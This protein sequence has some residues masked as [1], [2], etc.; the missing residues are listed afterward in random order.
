MKLL[1]LADL[2][3]GKRV[4]EFPMLADQRFVLEEALDIVRDLGVDALLVAGDLYD[5]ATPSAEAVA[6]VDWFLGEAVATGAHVLAVPGNHDSAERV[7]YASGLLARQGV[8]LPPVFDGTVA[9]CTLEDAYGPVT[10][11]LVPFLKPATVRP[12]FPDDAV[13][14]YTD[15][16]RLVVASCEVDPNGR[17]VA[18]AHQFVTAGSV[19]PERSDS[20]VAPVGGLDNVDAGV[21]EPFDYVALG[22]IHRPQRIGRDTVRYAGSPLK[23]SFSEI[24][25]PKSAPLVELGPKGEVTVELV[26]LTPLHDMRRLRG[27]LDELVAPAAVAA[28]DP[29]DY[30]QVVLTDE[31]PAPD[32]LSRLRAVFPNVMALEYDNARTRCSAD[33]ADLPNLARRNPLELFEEFYERQN[34]QPLSPGQRALAAREL[35]G[36]EAM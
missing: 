30:L 26:A 27:P 7:A 16:L 25:Y 18:L 29:Q 35:D 15:A 1:H 2:H 24:P 9:R 21:F 10:F 23:Y 12:F 8:H 17:N 20:E 3:I 28:G 14:T 19:E 6:L 22:H 13:E 32:A 33:T 4:N 34:G 5:K 36:I 11:W 31:H